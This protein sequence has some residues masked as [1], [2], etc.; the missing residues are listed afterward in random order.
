MK[1]KFLVKDV[2]FVDG[3]VGELAIE[4]D[5]TVDEFATLLKTQEDVIKQVLRAAAPIIA[6]VTV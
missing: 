3:H 1:A 4:V 5:Y 2:R 6:K